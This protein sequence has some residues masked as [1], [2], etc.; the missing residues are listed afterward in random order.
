MATNYSKLTNQYV[1]RK[2]EVTL[3]VEETPEVK[4]ATFLTHVVILAEVLSTLYA[5]PTPAEFMR[6]KRI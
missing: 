4:H 6:F 2:P 5:L 1:T 3:N